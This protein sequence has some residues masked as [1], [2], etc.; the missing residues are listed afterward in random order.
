M[1]FRINLHSHNLATGSDGPSL[2]G[3]PIWIDNNPEDF[4]LTVSDKRDALAGVLWFLSHAKEGLNLTAAGYLKPADVEA[5]AAVLPEAGRWLGKR[6]REDLTPPVAEFRQAMHG[7]GL[8]RKSKGRLVLTPAGRYFRDDPDALWQ[9]LVEKITPEPGTFAHD[10]V[11]LVLIHTLDGHRWDIATVCDQL[12]GMGWSHSK[13]GLPVQPQDL[14]F[15]KSQV[16]AVLDNMIP[17]G[18]SWWHHDVAMPIAARAFAYEALVADRAS[19]LSGPGRPYQRSR[20]EPP[21]TG[22][23]TAEEHSDMH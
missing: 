14:W 20:P 1:A 21:S 5:L 15:C 4:A 16:D 11:M 12:T 3:F 18:L 8:I 17:P 22:Q 2:P 9:V 13:T 6:N 7:F 10:F 23:R 19:V